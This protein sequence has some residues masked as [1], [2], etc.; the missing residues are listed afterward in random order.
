MKFSAIVGAWLL[1]SVGLALGAS[2]SGAPLR[3]KDVSDADIA[4]WSR[5]VELTDGASS[6]LSRE[7]KAEEIV[8]LYA[9]AERLADD[10]TPELQLRLDR[11]AEELAA[12]HLEEQLRRVAV[13]GE[14]EVRAAFEVRR[15]RLRRPRLVRLSDLF[16]RFPDGASEEQRAATRK[17]LE[18]LRDRVVAGESFALLAQAE[19]DSST[20]DRGGAAGFVAPEDLL[21]ELA[22]VVSGMK[23]GDLSPVI[24]L[25]GGAVLLLCG[26][27]DPGY[28]PSFAADRSVVESELLEE[29]VASRRAEIDARVAGKLAAGQPEESS[30]ESP[31][32]ARSRLLEAEA[33]ALGWVEGADDALLSRYRSLAVRA[34]LA[35]DDFAAS[36]VGE[37]T[38]EEVRSAWESTRSSWFEPRRRHLRALTIDIDRTKSG[39]M[40][41][42]FLAAGRTLAAAE[43]GPN[44]LEKVRDAVA[45]EGRL[46]DLGWLA[47][48][49]IWALGR[50]AT[51]AIGGMTVGRFTAAVQEGRRLRIFELVA[52]RERRE[53]TAAE[54]EPEVK[55]WRVAVRRK[56]AVQQLRRTIVD[57]A[58]DPGADS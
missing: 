28:E 37:P 58:R 6:S 17:S 38:E 40:Y 7:R 10:S 18:N 1:S 51:S 15:E 20:R 11:L 8:I 56:A 21:P 32:T 42:S 49:E 9:L 39:G 30:K 19:S 27:I 25:P 22:R 36:A 52:E 34:Q 53:K 23:P 5:Y 43:P 16:K 48:D 14:A 47:D 29:R 35:A 54:A 3:L 33:R 2:P 55:S 12:R 46:E 45:P 57:A 44:T 13:P 4:A 50:N 26:G 31:G 24:D 41:E